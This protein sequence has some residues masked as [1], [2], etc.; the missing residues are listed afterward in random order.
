MTQ[1]A[2]LRCDPKAPRLSPAEIVAQL[3]LVP[4]WQVVEDGAA[5]SRTL[6]FADYWETMAFVNAVAW[7]AHGEDHHPDL[8]V[9]FDR[10]V[11]RYQTHTVRGLS[12]NDFVCAARVNALLR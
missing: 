3:A 8:S 6:T 7:I 2:S 12:Q 5:L 9:H 11:V 1:L 10:C 4:G